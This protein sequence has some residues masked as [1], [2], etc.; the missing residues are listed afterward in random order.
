MRT[1]ARFFRDETA[2][3]SVKYGLIAASISLAIVTVI[4]G[5]GPKVRDVIIAAE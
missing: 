3:S 5:V 2:T 4:H 1:L